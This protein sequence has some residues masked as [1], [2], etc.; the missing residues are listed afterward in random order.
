MKKNKMG[1]MPIKKLVITMS[2]PVIFSMM[3]QALYNFVDSLYVARINEQALTALGL[4][5]PLQMIIIAVF[6]GLGVGINS[7]I[8]RKLGEKDH[9]TAVLVAEHG[10]L[11]GLI[12]YVFVA[13]AGYFSAAY[14]FGIFTKDPQIIEYGIAYIRIVM[15]FSFGRILAQAGMSVFQGT[16]EMVK[17]MITQLIG[18][19]VNIILDPILIFG[20]FGLP[21]MGVQG[22]AIATV[23]AQALSMI[24]VWGHLLLGN[25][26]IKPNLKKF[27]AQGHIIKQIIVVGIPVALMQGLTSVMLIGFNFIL[28]SY[29][30]TAIA[31][32]S[33]YFRLQSM[34]FMPVFGLS[35]GTLPIVGFNFGAKNKQRFDEAVKFSVIVAFV[36][37]VFCLLVFQLM[38]ETLL[39]LYKSSDEMMA[40]GLPAFKAISY[41]FPLVGISVIL[42]TTFQALGKAHYSLAMTV[43]RQLVVLLPAAYLLSKYGGINAVWY[44]FL[45]AE[46]VG[47]IVVIFMYKS[48]YRRIDWSPRTFNSETP[49]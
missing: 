1:I 18:A 44:A 33:A 13:V 47:I 10:V 49:S 16:G 22:A 35:T 11:L 4:A 42:S 37:M 38:P 41:M 31:V 36:F 20:W 12:L 7:S 14:F 15:V 29:G 28:S 30:D 45:I 43:I 21:A 9:E 8:A 19:V 39:K 48:I 26:I 27:K 2:L 5:F 46:I 17:P 40:I 23:F 6:V 32:L 24:Y 3:I 25:N 34:V